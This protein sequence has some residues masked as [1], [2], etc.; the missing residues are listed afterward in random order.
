MI[1]KKSLVEELREAIN[2]QSLEIL[3]LQQL[4]FK[5]SDDYA[6][7][8][9]G[10]DEMEDGFQQIIL[11]SVDHIKARDE[12]IAA[13]QAIV[14]DHDLNCLPVL[15]LTGKNYTPLDEDVS[16]T[17]REDNVKPDSAPD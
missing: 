16:T 6:A 12:K 11:D 13:L 5:M 15:V 3:Q 10:R 8:E 14:D 9:E 2:A 1:R 4:V 7:L 17:E